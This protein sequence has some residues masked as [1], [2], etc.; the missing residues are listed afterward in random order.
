MR[1]TIDL[2]R[3][4]FISSHR[5]RIVLRDVILEGE[6]ILYMLVNT[7][8]T[9][10]MIVE[11]WIMAEFIRLGDRFRTLRSFGHDDLGRLVID[12]G[13]AKDLIYPLPEE[14]SFAIKWPGRRVGSAERNPI[15]GTCYFVG[16]L[17]YEDERKVRRRS[18]FRRKFDGV[19][20]VFVRLSPD[21]ERDHEYAD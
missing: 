13:E 16:A 10:A 7:G 15:L 20:A 21:E 12:A 8:D 2:A 3:Q 9:S 19:K 6:N 11:S 5:P 4:E 17:V 18:V 1:A 14:I